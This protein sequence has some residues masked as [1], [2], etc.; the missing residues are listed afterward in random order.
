M[1]EKETLLRGVKKLRQAGVRLEKECVIYADPFNLLTP[2]N[3]AACILI[4]H[5]HYD[6]YSPEDIRRV[7]RED[8]TFV[9]P[10]DVCALL[11]GEFPQAKLIE[12]AP[13]DMLSFGGVGIEV[14]PSYNI[15]KPFHPQS[16]GWVGY[17]VRTADGSYYLPGDCD[18]TPEFLSAEADVFFVPIG[19]TYTMN[20]EE[21]ADAVNR[22]KPRL[23][24]PFHFGDV[25]KVG[26]REDG[27]RFLSLLDGVEGILL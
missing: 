23:A 26:S 1:T 17:I 15:G 14:L 21:A 2:T 19:G 12:V 20:V 16:K 6:H 7:M 13:G 8:T 3:D 24:I 4:T 5:A 11:A 22:A 10:K 25:E 9:A 27:E 18:A